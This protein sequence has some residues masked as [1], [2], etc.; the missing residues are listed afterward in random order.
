MIGL[1]RKHGKQHSIDFFIKRYKLRPARARQMFEEAINLFYIDNSIDK[2]AY[3]NHYADQ[4]EEVAHHI[5]SNIR[6]SQDAER[7][8][9]LIK[10]ISILRQLDKED[11][12]S[13]PAEAYMKP[14]RIHSLD[15][16]VIE[17]PAVNRHEL[18]RQID[19]DLEI[20]EKDKLRLK[21]EA[22]I[23][24]FNFIERLHEL[25]EES[26]DQKS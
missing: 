24:P 1:Y 17:L 26:Q 18:A 7:F 20:P 22:L 8:A 23:E 2:K 14:I 3:R 19:E 4:L 6:N 12:P 21:N 9:K 16:T 5:K 10:E 15:P 25:Q 11:P 13:L